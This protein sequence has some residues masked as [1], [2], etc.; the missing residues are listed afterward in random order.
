MNARSDAALHAFLE[1]TAH[2]VAEPERKV[3]FTRDAIPPPPSRVALGRLV[4]LR[5]HHA[6]HG[7]TQSQCDALHLLAER[8]TCRALGLLLLARLFHPSGTPARIELT[9]PASEV[10]AL[11]LDYDLALSGRGVLGYRTRIES[12]SWWPC[13]SERYPVS[14][15]RVWP[16]MLPALSL[17]NEADCIGDD[18]S[19]RDVVR[20]AG[21]DTGNVL[22]ARVLLDACVAGGS[23]EIHLESALGFGGVA[24]GSAELSIWLPGSVRWREEW[25]VDAP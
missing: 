9:H 7:Y 12:W 22:L 14:D 4:I 5:G 11:L 10:R 21:T 19:R 15:Q 24:P 23:P 17:T 13:A 18:W 20:C 2:V 3:V 8:E 16:E 25:F 1:A 6:Y